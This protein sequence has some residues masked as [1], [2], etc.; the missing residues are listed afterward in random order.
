[1]L[2]RKEEIYTM[3]SAQEIYARK[4]SESTSSTFMLVNGQID[5]KFVLPR[6]NTMR[7]R[8]NDMRRNVPSL[9]KS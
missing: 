5:A 2:D 7:E 3:D 4:I 8:S 9:G 6:R 1:M